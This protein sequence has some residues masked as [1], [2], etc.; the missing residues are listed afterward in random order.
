VKLSDGHYERFTPKERIALVFEAVAR[1]DYTEAER[2]IQTCPQKSYR[3]PDMAFSEGIQ[4]IRDCCMQVLLLVE[5][6][7]GKALACLSVLVAAGGSEVKDKPDLHSE[8]VRAHAL[9]LAEISG[10]WAAWQKFCAEVGVDAEVVVRGCSGD[11]PEW[12]RDLNTPV[13]RGVIEP[14]PNTQA[15]TL[16]LL[17]EIWKAHRDLC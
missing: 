2:L 8:A 7:S 17:H 4:S 16:E 15:R 3:M 6:A 11:L 1:A 10:I 12:I 14:D 9:A 13:L 5:R